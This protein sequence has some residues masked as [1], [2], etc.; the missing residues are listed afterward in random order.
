MRQFVFNGFKAIK[1]VYF[2]FIYCYI[3]Y[4]NLVL[5]LKWSKL[6]TQVTWPCNRFDK[7]FNWQYNQDKRISTLWHQWLKKSESDIKE[8]ANVLMYS[9]DPFK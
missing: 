7:N 5:T 8:N 1:I 4:T 6:V 3:I 2:N 9:R